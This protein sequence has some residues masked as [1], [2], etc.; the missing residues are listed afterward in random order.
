MGGKSSKDSA[1]FVLSEPE[2]DLDPK[3]REFETRP[4]L[5]YDEVVYENGQKR[6]YSN[7]FRPTVEHLQRFFPQ[8]YVAIKKLYDAKVAYV[9][10]NDYCYS[11]NL[12]L[13]EYK[14][15]NIC[16]KMPLE[17]KELYGLIQKEFDAWQAVEK[18]KYEK[19]C[20]EKADLSITKVEN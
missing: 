11:N 8:S 2:L 12:P 7:R 5:L 3:C 10:S 17:Y 15:Y 4:V 20:R 1:V 16:Y 19:N 13:E 6:K 18:E 9:C 14:D